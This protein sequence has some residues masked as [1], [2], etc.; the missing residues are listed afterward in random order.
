MQAQA[1]IIYS[2]SC[3]NT[4]QHLD[5]E[6]LLSR[7][8]I[9][10]HT[11]VVAWGKFTPTLEDVLCRT[12]LPIFY[13]ENVMGIEGETDGINKKYLAAVMIVSRSSRKSTYSSWIRYFDEEEDTK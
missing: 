8:I 11:F 4:Q 5:L 10:T 13:E 3:S 2:R 6:V 1:S 9:K 12:H 7:R